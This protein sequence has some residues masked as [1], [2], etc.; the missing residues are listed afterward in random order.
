MGY[1][2][3]MNKA[4]SVRL[5]ILACAVALGG[6][7]APAQAASKDTY[8]HKMEVGQLL[9][10]NGDIDRAITAFKRAAEL[11]PD[12]H[13]PHLNLLNL[14]VQKG[15][16]EHIE[17]ATKHC[18]E[19]LKR[20]PGNKEAHLIL[21]NLLRTQAGF[22][23]DKDATNKK[24]EE[25]QAEVETALKMGAPKALCENTLGMILLQKGDSDGALKHIETALNIQN[26]FPDAHLIR[27]VLL[28]KAATKDLT[29]PINFKDTKLK[30]K[31]AEVVSELDLSIKQ[32]EKNAEAKNTRADIAFAMGEQEDALEWY[33]EATKDE[34]RYAQAWAG[35]ANTE[36]Q[37]ANKETDTDKKSERMSHAREA[38]EKAAR[39]K[40]DDK[41]ILYLLPVILEK[42]GDVPGAIAEFQKALMLEKDVVMRAT[43]NMHIQQ[44]QKR[45][46]IGVPT[47]LSVGEV[48]GTILPPGSVDNIKTDTSSGS[49]G[50]NLFTNGA[51]STPFANLIKIK[52]PPK[53]QK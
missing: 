28:F 33:D 51:L 42:Q 6:S 34:P 16:E 47:T 35:I 12:A 8:R 19:V 5:T 43:I 49:I 2:E 20:K 24:L 53:E 13:E 9:Y 50:N 30:A 15:G 21:G 32:K 17:Q 52:Q 1:P 26:T 10:F 38:A 14:H 46:L 11:N 27:G 39:I 7:F 22:E 37:M 41:N 18:Q 31:M 25:A 40:P 3:V 29:P 44:L 36:V 23:K 4:L 48:S 45:G